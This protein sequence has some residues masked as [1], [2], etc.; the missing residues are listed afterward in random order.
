MGV[1]CRACEKACERSED[2]DGNQTGL[3]LRG[4]SPLNHK[5]KIWANNREKVEVMSE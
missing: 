1:V 2:G 4:L 3:S 5:V